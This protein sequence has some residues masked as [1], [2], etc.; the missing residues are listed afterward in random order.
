MG[1]RLFDMKFAFGSDNGPRSAIWK[2]WAPAKAEDVY[3]APLSAS[4]SMKASFHGANHWQISFNSEF[5]KKMKSAGA[6]KLRGR[7]LD[8]WAADS[9]LGAGLSL[10]LRITTPRIAM[11]P[12]SPNESVTN[13]TWLPSP[14]SGQYGECAIIFSDSAVAS[15]HW[16]GQCSMGTGLILESALS[17]GHIWI[18]YCY[19]AMNEALEQRIK[20][21][22]QATR[23]APRVN[24]KDTT[25]DNPRLIA[26]GIEADGSRYLLDLGAP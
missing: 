18:V 6:W 21:T 12:T 25:P 17:S 1:K 22:K 13:M 10:A 14:P 4:A 9:N 11:L 23:S 24:L 5:E 19:S 20:S 3:C 16:P 7:H 26:G 2:V 15:D 8:S